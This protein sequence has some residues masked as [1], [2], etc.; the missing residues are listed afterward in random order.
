MSPP[1]MLCAPLETKYGVYTLSVEY[2]GAQENDLCGSWG[3][4]TV[5][6]TSPEAFQKQCPSWATCST[7]FF[8][9]TDTCEELVFVVKGLGNTTCVYTIADR[10]TLVGSCIEDLVY[11][12]CD[13]VSSLTW[14]PDPTQA[15]EPTDM[16]T[17]D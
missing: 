13:Y 10:Y 4:G 9:I 17:T 15:P 8:E 6:F 14:N 1:D 11:F 5:D 2:N 7:N 16:S 3:I 12:Q